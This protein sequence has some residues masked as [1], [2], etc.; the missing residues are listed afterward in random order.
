MPFFEKVCM[1]Y[2]FKDIDGDGEPDE[3]IFVKKECVFSLNF[4][5][6]KIETMHHFSNEMS[7]MPTFFSI[8]YDERYFTIA[9]VAD[10]YWLDIETKKEVDLD[11][12]FEVELIRQIIYDDEHKKFYFLT[13]KWKG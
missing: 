3:I 2:H 13:N 11:V 10:G 7:S 8:S 9:S 1:Q 12:L 5:T 4:I 6:E